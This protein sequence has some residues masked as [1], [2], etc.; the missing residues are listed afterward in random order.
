MRGAQG[1]HLSVFAA[2][3]VVL[4]ATAAAA[5][6]GLP[7]VAADEFTEAQRINTLR[8][9]GALS[10]AVAE[11]PVHALNGDFCTWPGVTCHRLRS[12]GVGAEVTITQDR[13]IH[14]PVDVQMSEVRITSLKVRTRALAEGSALLSNLAK[15]M[16]STTLIT[17]D[18]T[19]AN[20]TSELPVTWGTFTNLQY[21][22]LANNHFYGT[23]PAAWSALTSLTE[24]QL[25]GNDVS[26]TLPASWSTMKRLHKVELDNNAFT[27]TL[28]PSWWCMTSLPMLPIRGDGFCGGVAAPWTALRGLVPTADGAFHEACGDRNRASSIPAHRRRR[29][30]P[31]R[32]LRP[33]AGQ[34]LRGSRLRC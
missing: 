11:K 14:L 2:L 4:A 26:G 23:L 32:L 18:F 21:L 15:A 1:H 28:P 10:P 6:A 8:V 33:P 17:L 9:L 20:I 31:Q 24:F 30:R 3:V 27:G 16:P 7:A 13:F 34:P 29:R 22:R 5:G 25:Q 12:G 19:G